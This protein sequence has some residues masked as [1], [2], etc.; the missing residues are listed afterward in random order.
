MPNSVRIL[1]TSALL[2]VIYLVTG[3]VI[4]AVAL[5]VRDVSFYIY[6][7]LIASVA[8]AG[9]YFL[10]VSSRNR[11]ALI[12]VTYLVT[13]AANVIGIYVCLSH[14]SSNNS[15]I[16]LGAWL[17][18]STYLFYLV[19]DTP[20][21]ATRKSWLWINAV[22]IFAIVLAIP[23]ING[24]S[25]H[26]QNVSAPTHF[27]IYL[28]KSHFYRTTQHSRAHVRP[29]GRVRVGLHSPIS[30]NQTDEFDLLLK[31]VGRTSVTVGRISYENYLGYRRFR[32]HD[33]ESGELADT[34]RATSSIE[35]F[36]VH[37]VGAGVTINPITGLLWVKLDLPEKLS[38]NRLSSAYIVH[39]M[40]A[41]V[42]W[43]LV[44][45]SFLFLAPVEPRKRL[46]GC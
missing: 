2:N 4:L 1:L 28:D 10:L 30:S 32:L 17:L 39:V 27:R 35:N 22:I 11:T 8:T 6:V 15:L 31:A 23:D 45:F 43:E 44:W 14:W 3:I 41:L 16:F 5:P 24:V 29:P 46:T 20:V 36:R 21:S 25:L 9:P 37:K 13:V 33:I 7:V 12:I 18:V 40:R 42:L 38:L 34:I 19:A 26:L